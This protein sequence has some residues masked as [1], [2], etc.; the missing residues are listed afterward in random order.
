MILSLLQHYNKIIVFMQIHSLEG[1]SFSGKTTMAAALAKDPSVELISGYTFYSRKLGVTPPLGLPHSLEEARRCFDY[2]LGLE[3]HRSQDSVKAA[4]LGRKV[5]QD[6]SVISLYAYQRA[7][8]V[9]D[10]QPTDVT[11]PNYALERVHEAIRKGNVILP[12]TIGVMA[13]ATE[14]VY[15]ARKDRRGPVKQNAVFNDWRF[16]LLLTG[17]TL[18]SALL[19]VGDDKRIMKYESTDETSNFAEIYG[20]LTGLMGIESRYDSN[21]DRT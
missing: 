9:Y 10:S 2:F 6:K 4:T 13:C 15:D 7:R 8:S 3:Y 16:S 21:I 18:E 1:H 19:F 11:V 17:V 20:D 12:S 5:L 14:Q